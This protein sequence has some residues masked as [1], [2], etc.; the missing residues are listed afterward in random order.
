MRKLIIAASL[1]STSAL[2][3]VPQV[4]ISVQEPVVGVAVTETVESQPDL[5]LFDVGVNTTASTATAALTENARKMDNIIA[6]LKAAGVAERDIQTTGI[7][8]YPQHSEPPR[9]AAGGYGPPRIVGYNAANNVRVR[10]R[11]LGDVGTLIDA[12]VGA[13]ATN[14]NGPMFSIEDPTARVRQARDKALAAAQERANEYARHYGARSARLLSVTEGGHGRP[15]N[16]SIIVTGAR[17]STLDV[18]AAPPPPPSPVQPGQIA[19]S[20][21]LFVQYA[22]ER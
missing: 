19:T 3:Q 17:M 11:R 12:L 22:L 8:L 20:M 16:D 1:L 4:N 21:S 18:A 5:A 13:G 14:I 6:R 9:L 15:F 7:Q 2:A 10:Y